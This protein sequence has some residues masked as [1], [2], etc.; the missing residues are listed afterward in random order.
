MTKTDKIEQWLTGWLRFCQAL[1]PVSIKRATH[2]S[3][4][5]CPILQAD[6]MVSNEIDRTRMT[7]VS[8]V[9]IVL[10]YAGVPHPHTARG[11][12]AHGAGQ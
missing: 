7:I 4:F 6:H 2:D 12:F 5:N 9:S 11:F 8:I 10:Y 3:R 1:W